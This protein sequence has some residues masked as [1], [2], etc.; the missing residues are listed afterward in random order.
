MYGDN[1]RQ[2]CQWEPSLG[3]GGILYPPGGEPGP[4]GCKSKKPGCYQKQASGNLVPARTDTAP[5]YGWTKKTCC[6]P[7]MLASGVWCSCSP[8]YM[9]FDTVDYHKKHTKTDI[10]IQGG[11]IGI[12]V[13]EK[14]KSFTHGGVGVL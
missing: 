14:Y 3:G 11:N 4:V 9:T 10:L 8:I 1:P 7:H 5:R 12:A 6:D 13:V 2:G